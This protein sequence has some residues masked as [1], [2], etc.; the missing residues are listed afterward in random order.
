MRQTAMKRHI[1]WLKCRVAISKEL[2]ETLLN[3]EKEQLEDFKKNDIGNLGQFIVDTMDK[4]AD[5]QTKELKKD[6]VRYTSLNLEY[7]NQ[8]KELREE[9]ERLKDKIRNFEHPF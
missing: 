6:I 5:Q 3:E 7:L 1:E 2:E 9:I 8:I 4:Y